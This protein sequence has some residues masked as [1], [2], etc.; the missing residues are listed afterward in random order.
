M[1]TSSFVT[2]RKTHSIEKFPGGGYRIGL[3]EIRVPREGRRIVA[4]GRRQGQSVLGAKAHR[5]YARRARVI[6]EPVGAAGVL[7]VAVDPDHDV[8][9]LEHS[10]YRGRANR[11]QIQRVDRL[12]LHALVECVAVVRQVIP[13][14]AEQ[15]ARCVVLAKKY[16]FIFY[17]FN[18]TGR[19]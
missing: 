3:L 17:L 4:L 15:L 6:A 12:D 18:K 14:H 19:I 1:K 7:V 10:H 13:R 8:A 11:R 2:T 9:V 16:L 5:E